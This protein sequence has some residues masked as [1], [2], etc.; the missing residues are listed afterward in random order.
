MDHSGH[1]KAYNGSIEFSG[2]ASGIVGD[3]HEYG[4]KYNIQHHH[5]NYYGPPSTE[6]RALLTD[7]A[8]G[9]YVSSTGKGLALLAL[10]GGPVD[11]LGSLYVLKRFMGKIAE[12]QGL[13]QPPKPCEFFDMISGAGVGGQVHTSFPV[14]G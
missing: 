6:P 12:M 13:P 11:G 4:P 8:H 1:P 7:Y 5:H 3:V 10:D 2:S 14:L 9:Q